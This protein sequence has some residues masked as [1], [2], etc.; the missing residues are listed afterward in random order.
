MNPFQR[1]RQLRRKLRHRLTVPSKPQLIHWARQVRAVTQPT[2]VTYLGMKKYV[3][4]QSYDPARPSLIVVSHEASATGAPILVWNLCQYFSETYNIIVLLLRPGAMIPDFQEYSIAVLR[5]SQETVIPAQLKR[6]LHGLLGS[7]L[8]KVAVVN[9]IVSNPFIKPLRGLGIGVV[10]LIH[11]FP[12]SLRPTHLFTDIGIWSTRLVFSSDLTRDDLYHSFPQLQALRTSVFA[13]GP[14]KRPDRPGRVAAAQP[15]VA[16]LDAQELLAGL[17]STTLFVL[18]AGEVQ[19]RKGVD[20]FIAVANKIRTMCP[21]V[22]VRFAWIGCGYDPIHDTQL[23][24][25]LQDQ[26]VRSGLEEDLRMLE[27]SNAYKSLLERCDLFLMP[28]RLDPLPNVA[29]DALLA[30][31]PV[32]SFENACGIASILLKDPELGPAWVAPYFDVHR[33]ATQAKEMLLNHEHRSRLTERSREL[34]RQWFDMPTYCQELASIVEQTAEEVG[35]ENQCV[36]QMLQAQIIDHVFASPLASDDHALATMEYV[37]SW[38]QNV[39]PRKPFP[40]FHPGIYREQCLNDNSTLDPTLHFYQSG[41]PDGLWKIPLLIGSNTQPDSVKSARAALHI[42]VSR[43]ETLPHILDLI[44]CNKLQPDIFITSNDHSIEHAV[45][46]EHS[47]RGL[48]LK[49]HLVVPARG[50]DLAPLLLELLD[51]LDHNYDFYGHV[52][53]SHEHALANSIPGKYQQFLLYNMIGNGNYSMLDQIASK[54][55]EDSSLGLVFPADSICFELGSNKI[56]VETLATRLGIPCLPHWLDYP[57]GSMF[58]VRSYCLSGYK[59]LN[60]KWREYPAN[61]FDNKHLLVDSILRTTPLVVE[62][63]G[64]KILQTHVPGWSR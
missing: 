63:A 60:L 62:R 10:S 57:A 8:P 48:L 51:R 59:S 28:S 45:E 42:H 20:L 19:Q 14:C 3:G 33:M 64:L 35:S 39:W 18:A 26:I 41:A 49:D 27:H 25:W 1:L 16:G 29:V 17:D 44:C 24:L 53:T 11:E 61:L 54:F 13:Q 4:K 37:L 6:E 12:S 23:S 50:S 9:S 34:A 30:G 46:A 47:K 22:K 5:A 15:G 55:V 38:R 2:L 32:L 7:D 56:N 58:W 21:D 31:K 36:S 43:V 40:G 52:H